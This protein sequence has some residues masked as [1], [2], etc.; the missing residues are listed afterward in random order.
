MSPS[1]FAVT[2]P[3]DPASYSWEATDEGV[4]ERFGVPDRPGAALRPQHLARAARAPGRAARRR[5]VRDHALR[6]PARR[7]PQ[8]GRGGRRRVRRDDRR[9]RAG[10]GRRR[11]PRH[12]HQG[13]P[14]RGSRRPSISIPTYPMYR[15]HAE[16]RGARVIAVPR[17]GRDEGWALDVAGVREGR[18]GGHPRL[19]L[20][21][22]QPDRPGG[23]RR[24]DRGAPRRPRGRR[25]GRRPTRSC[26]RRR[27]GVQRVHRP[28]RDRPPDQVSEPRRR[29]DRLEGLRAR[30]PAGRVRDR[31]SGHAPTRGAVPA[32][33]V[34]QHRVGDRRDGGPA[35]SAGDARQRRPR[36]ARAAAPRSPAWRRPAGG[37]SR[38]SRTSCCW[39]SS[40]PNAPRPPRSH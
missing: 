30:R 5:P 26:G 40:R 34:H 36:R 4:A 15:I 9:D 11:D 17:L 22:E 27:R 1:P 31:R 20:Q 16:Q 19:D 23:A 14:A 8:P 25:R 18:Q 29:E 13:V 7:L 21:P 35:R 39:T 33:G 2:S 10:R 6:V 24:R 32:A 12:V 3:T 37:R 28:V 38:R